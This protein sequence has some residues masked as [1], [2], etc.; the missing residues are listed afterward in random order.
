MKKADEKLTQGYMRRMKI[1]LLGA[2]VLTLSGALRAQTSLSEGTLFGFIQRETVK[3]KMSLEPAL[4]AQWENVEDSS[5]YELNQTRH[6]FLGAGVAQSFADYQLPFGIGEIGWASTGIY[7]TW[8]SAVSSYRI[9][10][11]AQAEMLP[12]PGEAKSFAQWKVGDSLFWRRGKGI[13]VYAGIGAG[14]IGVGM[15]VG[16]KFLLAGSF[17]VYLEKKSP[18]ELYI[19]VRPCTVRTA[20]V[21]G[22]MI[23]GY[24][25]AGIRVESYRRGMSFVVDPNSKMDRGVFKKIL[26]GRFSEVNKG[27]VR[28]NLAGV[29]RI[30]YAQWGV[31]TPY[32]PLFSYS[33]RLQTTDSEET[34]TDETASDTERVVD[35]MNERTSSVLGRYNGEVRG[36]R[37]YQDFEGK[38]HLSWRWEWETSKGGPVNL[39]RA[40]TRLKKRLDCGEICEFSTRGARGIMAYERVNATWETSLENLVSLS[41]RG[42][43]KSLN[44]ILRNCQE[45]PSKD[46]YRRLAK[47]ILNYKRPLKTM[48]GSSRECVNVKFTVG[49]ERVKRW[50]REGSYCP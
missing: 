15:G 44:R 34:R 33:R 13:G 45:S 14:V 16:P 11:S 23:V 41:E 19:E 21:L 40:L 37:F 43:L 4:R 48:F 22:S 1:F 7:P 18:T 3:R 42:G 49:G 32:L 47:T 27:Y 10:Q 36:V 8:E 30:G 25:E 20:S 35:Y 12:L 50:T 28:Q 46:C 39:A 26:Q 9:H 17:Q 31:S 29:R 5:W 24:G 38:T 2:I 6:Y